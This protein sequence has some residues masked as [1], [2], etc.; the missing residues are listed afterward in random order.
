MTILDKICFAGFKTWI[1][2]E[3]DPDDPQTLSKHDYFIAS[4]DRSVPSNVVLSPDVLV[5]LFKF[6]TNADPRVYISRDNDAICV[7]CCLDFQHADESYYYWAGFSESHL[8]GKKQIS[9]SFYQNDF[10]D[11]S[12]YLHDRQPSM[13][14]GSWMGEPQRKPYPSPF[15]P[16]PTP[17]LPFEYQEV[18][19]VRRL[20]GAILQMPAI[21][22]P[23]VAK[24]SFRFSGV[25]DSISGLF[26][27]NA[28]T[29][30]LLLRIVHDT[31]N[32]YFQIYVRGNTRAG[33]GLKFNI[34]E[35]EIDATVVYE[36]FE[37][38]FFANFNE[39]SGSVTLQTMTLSDTVRT[40]DIWGVN[41]D[42]SVCRIYEMVAIDVRDNSLMFDLVPCYRK[43]DGF[44]GFYDLVSSQFFTAQANAGEYDH[45]D[46][47]RV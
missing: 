33:N 46:R 39:Q 17:R 29:E 6:N 19:W 2:Y 14:F 3:P 31:D 26:Y 24:L 32:T 4:F 28:T 12:P 34:S 38:G 45:G 7:G 44:C 1:S 37:G 16:A 11:G 47:V 22:K 10:P 25:V 40:V 35:A 21:F 13:V 36:P 5:G 41:D 20:S 42:T 18:T 23:M 43:S 9:T 15:A 27:N 30:R 8:T